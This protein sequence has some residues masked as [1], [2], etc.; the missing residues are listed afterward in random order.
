MEEFPSKLTDTN[1]L[2]EAAVIESGAYAL[3]VYRN[4]GGPEGFYNLE[5]VY[6]HTEN[7][8]SLTLEDAKVLGA[9]MTHASWDQGEHAH[10]VVY[11]YDANKKIICVA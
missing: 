3:V 11:I 7:L 2:L 10:I 9:A 1:G 6:T 5:K 8:P 4:T